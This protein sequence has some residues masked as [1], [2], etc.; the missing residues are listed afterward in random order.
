M[1]LKGTQG[2]G[3]AFF[4]GANSYGAQALSRCLNSPRLSRLD[5][6]F[7]EIIFFS[8]PSALENFE[9]LVA[10]PLVIAN[11]PRSVSPETGKP[12]YFV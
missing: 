9:I 12:G 5:G 11:N 2:N 4:E 7:L 1:R 6:R 8:Q 3:I 10:S